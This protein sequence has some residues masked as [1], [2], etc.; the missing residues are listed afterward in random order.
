MLLIDCSYFIGLIQSRAKPPTRKFQLQAAESKAKPSFRNTDLRQICDSLQAC[1][2]WDGSV[3]IVFESEKGEELN[4]SIF[5]QG[6]PN[7]R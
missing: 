6:S 4:E 5:L 2:T 3:K 7:R 1:P